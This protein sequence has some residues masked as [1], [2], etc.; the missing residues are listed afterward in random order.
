[1]KSWSYIYKFTELGDARKMEAGSEND[2]GMIS[3]Q[4]WGRDQER[5]LM[6][7]SMKVNVTEKLLAEELVNTPET[8][9]RQR[10][11]RNI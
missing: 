8:L 6:E 2:K 4:W 9:K 10:S 1:M 5:A 11:T 7:A 3:G